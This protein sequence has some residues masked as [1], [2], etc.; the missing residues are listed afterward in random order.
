MLT[1]NILEIL[2][3]I[4]PLLGLIYTIFH[5]SHIFDRSKV[6]YDIFTEIGDLDPLYEDYVNPLIYLLIYVIGIGIIAY[7][8]IT[9]IIPDI[10]VIFL[11]IML[12]SLIF[13]I[14]ATYSKE[15]GK[16]PKDKVKSYKVVYLLFNIYILLAIGI[17]YSTLTILP[18][19]TLNFLFLPIYYILTPFLIISAS[20]Y[21][22]VFIEY[23]LYHFIR[24]KALQR[25]NQYFRDKPEKLKMDILLK[26]GDR[27][28]GTFAALYIESLFLINSEDML[29]EIK[30]KQ[31]EILGCKFIKVNK[32]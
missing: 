11:I 24:E 20:L 17:I 23:V 30:Y 10:F 2:T 26:N 22:L 21:L 9:R 31:I 7:I 8:N 29:Y 32:E 18:S 19:I 14:I 25:L 5:N 15:P 12:V 6:L 16:I 13:L 4:I 28:N 1:K 3:V 27:L